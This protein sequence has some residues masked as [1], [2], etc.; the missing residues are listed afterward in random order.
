MA[1]EIIRRHGE[2]LR[3]PKDWRE[4]LLKRSE[5]EVETLTILMLWRIE[6]GRRLLS[7]SHAEMLISELGRSATARRTIEKTYLNQIWLNDFFDRIFFFI[8]RR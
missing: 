7:G 4:I 8:N 1:C 6:Q 2:R 5:V 3:T